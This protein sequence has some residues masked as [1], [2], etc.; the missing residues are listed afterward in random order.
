MYRS[1]QKARGPVRWSVICKK[2]F[3]PRPCPT[4]TKVE[5][6]SSELDASTQTH[7]FKAEVT[8]GGFGQYEWTFEG[9]TAVVKTDVPE[10][11]HAFER[12][13]GDAEKRKVTVTGLGITPCPATA[14][15]E[16]EIP[17]VCPTISIHN[18]RIE[19]FDE[20]DKTVTV[21]A[22]LNVSGDMPDTCAWDWGDGS[23]P[24]NTV[25][26]EVSHVY[27][28]P[29]GDSEGY[30]I[31]VTANGPDSLFSRCRRKG[32]NSWYLSLDYGDF[33]YS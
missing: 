10:V 5:S 27:N 6:L 23:A 22:T 20:T 21:K 14:E 13:S 32:I 19:P 33:S 28:R 26:T 16:V 30:I 29:A 2:I 4:I 15:T 25:E 31:K 11:T 7:T 12:P 18:I 1:L 9:E 24:E 17:G 8:K 3:P